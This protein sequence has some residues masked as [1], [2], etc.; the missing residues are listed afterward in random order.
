MADAKLISFGLSLPGSIE[1]TNWRARSQTAPRPHP[2]TS[3]LQAGPRPRQLPIEHARRVAM[4]S[5]KSQARGHLS[6]FPVRLASSAAVPEP[7]P[8]GLLS[9]RGK[10]I[11]AEQEAAFSHS[12]RWQAS[13]LFDGTYGS[14]RSSCRQSFVAAVLSRY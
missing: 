6:I 4:E 11:Q 1:L 2:L 3:M 12:R 8:T 14:V 10:K 7:L 9:C 5:D 13:S